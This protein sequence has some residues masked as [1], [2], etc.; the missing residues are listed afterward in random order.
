[1]RHEFTRRQL[2]LGLPLALAGCAAGPPYTAAAVTDSGYAATYGA[3]KD[4]PYTIP[5][6]DL[7]G[8]DPGVLRQDVPYR[9]SYQPGTVII[10]IGERRLYL[11]EDGGRARRFG[12]GVGREEA[13]NFRGSAIIGRKA[14]WPSWTPTQNMIARIPKY[15]AYADGMRGGPGNPLGARAL[16][17]YRNDQDTHFRVHGTNEPKSIGKAA[18]SGCIRLFNHDIVYLYDRLAIGTPVVVLHGAAS[19]SLPQ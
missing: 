7:A 19:E 2:M 11:V 9:G 4:P 5:A 1:M 12:I 3:L 14:K 16:Y 15:A 8:I 10:S 18:S 6:L 13:L 17:L